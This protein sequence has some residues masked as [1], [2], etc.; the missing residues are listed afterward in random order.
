M[1]QKSNLGRNEKDERDLNGIMKKQ[2]DNFR[3]KADYAIYKK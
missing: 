1:N 3:K 2:V